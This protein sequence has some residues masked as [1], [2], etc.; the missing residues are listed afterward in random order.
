MSA[1]VPVSAGTYTFQAAAEG[2]G[3]GATAEVGGGT[4]SYSEG[5]L[6]VLILGD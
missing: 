5:T 3:V 4:N 1:V 6:S 2:A